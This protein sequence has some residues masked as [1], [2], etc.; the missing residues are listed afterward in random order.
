MK[1]EAGG[2]NQPQGM[3]NGDKKSD[4]H[5]AAYDAGSPA[6]SPTASAGEV[7][8]AME[9]AGDALKEGVSNGGKNMVEAG[10]EAATQVVEPQW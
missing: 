5:A 10:S 8:V 6:E 7:G 4:V 1:Q 3:S 2:A 9:S